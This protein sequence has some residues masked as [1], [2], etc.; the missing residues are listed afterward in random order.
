MKTWETLASRRGRQ[1]SMLS[2]GAS[3]RR[4]PPT[5]PG[6]WFSSLNP[7]TSC[8]ARQVAT[9]FAA[10]PVISEELRRSSDKVDWDSLTPHALEV[11]ESALKPRKQEW[12]VID[13]KPVPGAKQKVHD[14]LWFTGDAELGWAALPD[15]DDMPRMVDGS[16]L[17]W[18][19]VNTKLPNEEGYLDVRS[20]EA[21]VQAQFAVLTQRPRLTLS[22]LT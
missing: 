17:E 7:H 13:G 22:R 9:R 5:A 16:M 2:L 14:G 15:T 19:N 3:H 10:A 12:L 21:R 11:V 20:R 18:A 6:P 8:R 1:A 4:A